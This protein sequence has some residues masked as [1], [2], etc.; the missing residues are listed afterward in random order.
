[1]TGLPWLLVDQHADDDTVVAACTDIDGLFADR[2][3]PPAERYTL[4]ACLPSGRLRAAIDGFGPP[5]LGN[6]GLEAIHPSDSAHPPECW[7]CVEELLDLVVTDAQ[8]AAAGQGLLDITLEGRLRTD[9]PRF[10]RRSTATAPDAEGY[11]LAGITGEGEEKFGFCQDV[12]GVFHARPVPPPRPATLVGCRPGARL[13]RAIDALGSRNRR[14]ISASIF[15]VGADGSATHVL[16]AGFGAEVSAVTPSPL[17]EGLVDVTFEPKYGDVIGGPRPARAREV[18]EVWQAGRPTE[19]NR[20]SGYDALLRHE[21]AGAALAHHQQRPDR[22]GGTEFHLDGSHVTDEDGFYC[23][24]GE[25]INGPGGYFGW[26]PGALH[27]CALGG[28]GA[29]PGFRLIWHDA[30]VARRHLIPG[31]DRRLWAPAITMDHV[32]A[33]LADSG[34]HVELR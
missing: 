4:L 27:D 1:M 19:L 30:A 15:S 28:W 25:A 11:L 10:T 18:W 20:W 33:W 24:I 31:Y 2:P 23:A 8:P 14:M 26:N 3:E 34:V 6:I 12:S 29:A 9:L 5:W 32:L 17:G 13:Q 21:W 7:E 16:D 22:P